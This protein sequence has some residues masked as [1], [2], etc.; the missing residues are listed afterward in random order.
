[1]YISQGI[2]RYILCLALALQYTLRR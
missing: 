1:M 2:L